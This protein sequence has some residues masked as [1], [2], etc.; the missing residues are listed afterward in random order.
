MSGEWDAYIARYMQARR[1]ERIMVVLGIGAIV[2][3]LVV[4]IVQATP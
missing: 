3:V 1:N 2:A 4:Y